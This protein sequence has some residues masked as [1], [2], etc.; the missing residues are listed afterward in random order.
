[1]EN[2]NYRLENQC[3]VCHNSRR[4]ENGVIN[5]DHYTRYEPEPAII[6]NKWKLPYSLACAIKYIL[7][8]GFKEGESIETAIK[9]AIRHLNL[10]LES[11]K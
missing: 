4:D 9:K 3:Q 10:F 11:T 2:E 5:P 8:A 6:L 7:R 1:M